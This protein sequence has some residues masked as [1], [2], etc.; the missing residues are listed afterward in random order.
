MEKDDLIPYETAL[1]DHGASSTY[2]LAS[3]QGRIQS[4]SME[5]NSTWLSTALARNLGCNSIRWLWITRSRS[6]QMA[7]S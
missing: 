1:D 3:D 4:K 7:L 5:E 6:D 2:T